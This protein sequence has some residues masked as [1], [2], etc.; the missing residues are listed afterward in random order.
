MPNLIG[1][2]HTA[3]TIVFHRQDNPWA[4]RR[5]DD[6]LKTGQENRIKFDPT[7]APVVLKPSPNTSEDQL[8]WM[9]ATQR[10]LQSASFVYLQRTEEMLRFRQAV[11]HLGQHQSLVTVGSQAELQHFS[12]EQWMRVSHIY[13]LRH[14]GF[15]FDIERAAVHDKDLVATTPFEKIEIIGRLGESASTGQTHLTFDATGSVAHVELIAWRNSV[16]DQELGRFAPPN[17]RIALS[18]GNFHQPYTFCE[19]YHPEFKS[20]WFLF[21]P[22][23]I[24]KWMSRIKQRSVAG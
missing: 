24:A 8:P 22:K 17:H 4:F 11:H 5:L 18:I 13:A 7:L 10:L 21:S 1:Y 9:A 3:G 6:E 16:A 12:A 2:A 14:D 23:T 19:E 20:R 15:R